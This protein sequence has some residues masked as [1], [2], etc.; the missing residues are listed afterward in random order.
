MWYAIYPGLNLQIRAKV[1]LGSQYGVGTGATFNFTL[2]FT[3]VFL[4]EVITFVSFKLGS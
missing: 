1:A 2:T 4:L 3:S